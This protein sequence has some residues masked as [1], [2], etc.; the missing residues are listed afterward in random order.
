MPKKYPH[1]KLKSNVKEKEMEMVE[2][3]ELND[4]LLLL[5]YRQMKLEDRV[6]ALERRNCDDDSGKDSD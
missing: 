2:D 6:E 1:E 5:M 3:V 4:L